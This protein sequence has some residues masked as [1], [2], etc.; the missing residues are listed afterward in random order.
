MY[1][2]RGGVPSSKKVDSS[3]TVTTHSR[4][5]EHAERIRRVEEACCKPVSDL[6]R[7]RTSLL[8]GQTMALSHSW[9]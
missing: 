6:C 7:H 2:M 1:C 8:L 9:C 4:K 5:R 3:L